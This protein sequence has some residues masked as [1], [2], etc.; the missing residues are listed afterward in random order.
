MKFYRTFGISIFL[1]VA[2]GMWITATSEES[3][4]PFLGLPVLA[5]AY[6]YTGIRRT[7]LIS[8]RTATYLAL[9][10]FLWAWIESRLLGTAG[11]YSLTHF[12]ITVQIIM[13]LQPPSNRSYAVVMLVALLNVWVASALTTEMAFGVQ[14]IAFTIL[15]LWTLAL[16][17]FKVEA[18]GEEE[19]GRSRS[20]ITR[21][22]ALE[23]WRQVRGPFRVI[24]FS[25]VV[26]LAVAVATFAMLPRI[27]YPPV[28]GP[29]GLV[30]V[31]GFS[32]DVQIGDIAQIKESPQ[33]VMRVWIRE[34]GESV[35]VERLLIRGVA[36]AYY[37]GGAWR[38]GSPTSPAWRRRTTHQTRRVSVTGYQ[39]FELEPT[40]GGVLFALYPDV[41]RRRGDIAP[42][43][44]HVEDAPTLVEDPALDV[45]RMAFTPLKQ[46]KYAAV[47]AAETDGKNRQLS[48]VPLNQEDEATF[49]QLPDELSPGIQELAEN[50][51][52][53]SRYSTDL[54]RA[55]A[56]EAHLQSEYRYTLA[57]PVAGAGEPIAQFLFD[58]KEGYCEHFASA[59]VLMLRT[60]GIP[61]RLVNGYA[62]GEW[63][64]VGKYYIIRQQDAHSWVEAYFADRG[65]VTFDPTPA[66]GIIIY[67]TRG[68]WLKA[69]R[70]YDIIERLWVQRIV[71]YGD[72]NQREIARRFTGTVAAAASRFNQAARAIPQYTRELGR[73]FPAGT[74][75]MLGVLVIAAGLLAAVLSGAAAKL[76]RSRRRI[77]RAGYRRQPVDFYEGLLRILG[78]RG[79][80][81]AP[82][83]TPLEFA[84]EVATAGG[85]EYGL[86]THITEAFC[87]VRYGDLNL[88]DKARQEIRRAL[89]KIRKMKPARLRQTGSPVPAR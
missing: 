47:V 73:G 41:Y 66:A 56:I 22:A 2:L 27:P 70:T 29:G 30:G 23:R 34:S 75:G 32:E 85:A 63:N 71:N 57:P 43:F 84:R 20:A 4:V 61:A 46:V 69:A 13:L 50:I 21:S 40:S 55:G 78:R 74:V 35:Q 1:M 19:I 72:E 15:A 38:A 3:V 37:D 76:L 48:P 54:E 83:A 58:K 65:W 31:T 12:L 62:G 7:P 18:E 26:V 11:P 39:E 44:F 59:M 81:R 49:L 80:H 68:V 6:Y 9:A 24:A 67:P 5:A 42:V 88:D 77:R 89:E 10:S 8:R 51:A 16:M 14:F 45:V 53:R 86:V 25:S 60:L 52:P 82:D 33:K 17:H 36:L 28:T 87:G 79:F 64:D